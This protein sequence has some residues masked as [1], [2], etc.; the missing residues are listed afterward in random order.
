M[1]HRSDTI[2]GSR[3]WQTGTQAHAELIATARV[4]A[5]VVL[6][7]RLLARHDRGERHLQDT[8]RVTHRAV[9]RMREGYLTKENAQK[10]L[11]AHKARRD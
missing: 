8:I 1:A 4:P 10:I 6:Y 3:G 7:D 9:A 5:F 2:K 11:A